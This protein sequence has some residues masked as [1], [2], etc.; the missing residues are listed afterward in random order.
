MKITP[1]YVGQKLVC[2]A[3]A[4]GCWRSHIT[5]VS[6]RG[7]RKGTVV[8]CDG[9]DENGCVLLKEY[10]LT[11]A[12]GFEQAYERKGD[13]VESLKTRRI[14][15][16]LYEPALHNVSVEHETAKEVIQGTTIT[17]ASDMQKNLT[18]EDLLLAGEKK[19]KK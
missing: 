13:A 15:E 2:I 4:W 9:F 11:P 19:D 12:E 5:H 16:G 1:F 10:P 6:I 17:E 7:P 8:T 14:K 3:P 18:P